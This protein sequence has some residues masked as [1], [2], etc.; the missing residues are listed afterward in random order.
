MPDSILPFD[1]VPNT[2]LIYSTLLYS[3]LLYSTLLYSTL[4]LSFSDRFLLP[5]PTLLYLTSS[6]RLISPSHLILFYRNIGMGFSLRWCEVALDVSGGDFNE[7]IYILDNN[8]NFKFDF[9]ECVDQ[10]SPLSKSLPFSFYFNR[11][12]VSFSFYLF[13]MHYT[14]I[15]ILFYYINRQSITSC[16]TEKLWNK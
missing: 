16:P 3:T 1:E 7:V 13:I 15:S 14:L 5:S 9:F 11:G 8:W 4:A 10:F 12:V 6:F 2:S